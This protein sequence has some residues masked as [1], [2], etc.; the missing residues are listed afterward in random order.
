MIA[1]LLLATLAAT[2]PQVVAVFDVR[3]ERP[4]AERLDD[5]TLASLTTYL[6]TLLTKSGQYR[7]VP[8]S[9]LQR[10]LRDAKRESLE[11]CYDERCQI[12]IGKAL[13]A[14]L[15]L[16]TSIGRVGS[17]CVLTSRLFDLREEATVRAASH[18]G[19]CGDDAL[20]N[21]VERLVEELVNGVATEA[22]TVTSKMTLQLNGIE[23][24]R[25]A[26][27]GEDPAWN[28]HLQRVRTE[29]DDDDVRLYLGSGLTYAAW[30][31][32]TN[33]ASESVVL[34]IVKWASTALSV[35]ALGVLVFDETSRDAA[36]F[37]L[38]TTTLAFGPALL[39]WTFDLVNVG[40][41]PTGL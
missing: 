35:V 25:A 10:A 1:S 13:A 3:D 16:Q 26:F 4:A 39:S 20:T 17:S 28:A 19:E 21:G 6:G 24:T 7:V 12:E 15:S 11:L 41:V 23:A 31:K 36:G 33:D 32:K 8:S 37:W 22:P 34:E 5:P 2:D 27:A 29:L 14:Q 38:G 40:D 9:E 30:A 18:R